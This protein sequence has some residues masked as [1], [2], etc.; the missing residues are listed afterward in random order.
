MPEQT[1]SEKIDFSKS[2][3]YTL[4]IRLSADGFSFFIYNPIANHSFCFIPRQINQ[5]CSMAANVKAAVRETDFLVHSYKRVNVLLVSKRF[6]L[7]PFELFEDEQIE[8]IFYH[9]FSRLENELILYTVLRKANV[10]VAFSI[11][12]S[13][14]QEL[15]NLFPRVNFYS[16]ASSLI[17]YFVEKSRLGNSN[18]MYAYLRQKSMDIYCFERGK[19][20]FSNSFKCENTEDRVYYLLYLWKQLSFSQ[21]RDELHLVGELDNKD[22]LIAELRKYL[23][24]VF[25]VNPKSEFNNSELTRIEDIPF[26][27]QAL[28]EI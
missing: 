4:F 2:E 21:E 23:N 6:T 13:V 17:E 22:I 11:D 8:A 12:K 18:K 20:L 14:Y 25:I 19:L 1:I 10:A 7:I 28:L 15:I 5:T 3:Q 26:D 16:Q 24:R 27:L 9:N